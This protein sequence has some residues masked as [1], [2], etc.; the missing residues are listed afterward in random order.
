MTDVDNLM[1]IE[2]DKLEKLSVNYAHEMKYLSKRIRKDI[3]IP[4][5][6]SQKL[7]Y[8]LNKITKVFAMMN[9]IIGLDAFFTL[10][11]V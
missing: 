6:N 8:F 9:D 5:A 1:L 2:L 11:T 4:G 7:A 3:W 10:D